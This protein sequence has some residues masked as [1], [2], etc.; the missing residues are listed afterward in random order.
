[1][2]NSIMKKLPFWFPKKVNFVWY[3]VFISLFLLS[4]DFWA[5]NQ[6]EP[7]FLGLPFWVYYFIILTFFTAGI[8]YAHPSLS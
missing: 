2:G 8:F 1:M 7:L 3:I 6:A 4:L 5:W